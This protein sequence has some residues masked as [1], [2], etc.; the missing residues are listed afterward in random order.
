[1]INNLENLG[2]KCYTREGEVEIG[3]YEFDTIVEAG[4]KDNLTHLKNEKNS[5]LVSII[6]ELYYVMA[7]EN[8]D[9]NNN[10]ENNR[11]FM[12]QLELVDQ[13]HQALLL[14]KQI[15]FS[16][17]QGSID[18]INNYCKNG[19]DIQDIGW[20]MRKENFLR[21]CGYREPCDFIYDFLESYVV[22]NQDAWYKDNLRLYKQ[23]FNAKIDIDIYRQKHDLHSFEPGSIMVWFELFSVLR[24]EFFG[25]KGELAWMYFLL[26]MFRHICEETESTRFEWLEIEATEDWQGQLNTIIRQTTDEI[27][28][29]INRK[30]L[31]LQEN[32]LSCQFMVA[33]MESDVFD[34]KVEILLDALKQLSRQK[35]YAGCLKR[36]INKQ[37]SG[38]VAIMHCNARKYAALSGSKNSNILLI[39]LERILGPEYTVVDLNPDVRYYHTKDAYITYNQYCKWRDEVKFDESRLEEVKRMFSCCERKLLTEL[40]GRENYRYT[41]YVKKKVCNMCNRALNDFDA[42]NGCKGLIKYPKIESKSRTRTTLINRLDK[43]AKGVRDNTL[44][45]KSVYI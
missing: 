9:N 19:K 12:L 13:K 3:N 45:D 11:S 4:V 30:T 29:A 36:Y 21:F 25:I 2:W 1:M 22:D 16:E 23:F 41:I 37:D 27:E 15:Y 28:S 5:S 43:V 6:G 42:M 18:R 8:I 10:F 20:F 34:R 39:D 31:Q 17:V 14:F 44:P 7:L 33:T 38:C 32:M 35:N 26:T 40:Y 24:D